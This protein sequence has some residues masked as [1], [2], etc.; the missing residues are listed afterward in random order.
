MKNMKCNLTLALFILLIG[1]S[2]V[3]GQ[4]LLKQL[5]RGNVE[6][7]LYDNGFKIKD[8]STGTFIIETTSPTADLPIGFASYPNSTVDYVSYMYSVVKDSTAAYQWWTNTLLTWSS[9]DPLYI[10]DASFQNTSNAEVINM[11]V[12][13]LLNNKVKVEIQKATP[14]AQPW[15]YRTRLRLKLFPNE[16]FLGFGTRPEDVAFRNKKMLNWISEMRIANEPSPKPE[17]QGEARVPF[18]ISTRGYGLL[19]NEN[20][21]SSFD[22]GETDPNINEIATWEQHLNFTVYLGAT[23]IDIIQNY[24]EDAGRLLRT[25]EP[26][27]FGVWMLTKNRN[28]FQTETDRS[29][30]VAAVLRND[31]IPCSALWHHYWSKKILSI[32]GTGMSWQIDPTYWPNYNTLVNTHHNQGFK[33]LHYYWPYIFNNDAEYNY[34]NTQGYFMKNWLSTTYL[35]PWLVWFNQVAE[36]DLSRQTVR[37]WYKNNLMTNALSVGSSGWM[38]DF[39]EHH[40]IDMIDSANSNPYAVH[41]EYPLNWAITNQEFWEQNQPNGDYVYFMRGG[42]TGMQKYAPVMINDPDMSWETANGIK[43]QISNI[44]SGGISGHPLVCPHVGGYKYGAPVVLPSNLE[45]LWIRWLEMVAL[46]PV[47]WTHEGDELYLGAKQ[48]FDQ[49]PQ[50]QAM[51]K[52]YSKLHVKFFPYIYTLVK[53][54]KETGVPVVRSLYLHYPTDANTISIK[55]EFLLGDRVLVA[56]VLDSAATTKQ[57]YFPTGNWYDYWT[58]SLAASGPSTHTVSAPLAH[59]PIFV[60]EGTILPLYNQNHIETL[61]KNV[62]G[63]NDFEYADS[64]MELRFYGCGTDQFELWDSTLIQMHRYTGDSLTTISGGQ[65]RLYSSTFIYNNT[66]NCF[67]GISENT[68]E[69]SLIV[70]PNPT[71]GITTVDVEISLNTES[72]IEI[73]N[74]S[75]SLVQSEKLILT[76]GD[77]K[78]QIDIS[79]LTNGIYLL[80]VSANNEYKTIKVVKH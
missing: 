80:K 14:V 69:A 50:T 10:I 62:P 61:V 22:L 75:G 37:N 26:W 34:A 15:K 23:P 52:K 24:T 30:Q 40:R 77:T 48:V 16:Y 33:V 32:L 21:C 39:G 12:Q 13:L 7:N 25:P 74:L 1:F 60:K 19:L 6:F 18:Y 27:V 76:S 72:K 57:V 47:L 70:Y 43:G 56:P 38:A 68:Q 54:A 4:T 44:L 55:D 5:S 71:T 78:K 36:P 79:N 63:V 8:L 58:G 51:F 42:W 41:N 11:H 49:S 31:S 53:E 3:S 45:E 28:G 46:I 59:L 66:V 17:N 29:N 65:P 67:V 2:N 35:N 9:N 73:Y 20:T 64:T